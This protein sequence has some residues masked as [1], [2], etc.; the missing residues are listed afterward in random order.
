MIIFI[1]CYLYIGVKM[2]KAYKIALAI[3]WARKLAHK[4]C[5]KNA[6]KIQK[7]A[8][9]P[10]IGQQKAKN[11]LFKREKNK[12]ENSYEKLAQAARP[13]PPPFSISAWVDIIS[14]N[15]FHTQNLISSVFIE[16]LCHQRTQIWIMPPKY[17]LV[18]IFYRMALN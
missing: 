10:K 3:L 16:S 11:F 5:A 6:K 15:N 1:Y 4:I 13:I 18:N 2:E 17:Y 8:K 14:L 7:Y 9:R 12:N